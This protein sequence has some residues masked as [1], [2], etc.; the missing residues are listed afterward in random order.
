MGRQEGSR[1]TY[2]RS[3]TL[4]TVQAKQATA[5]KAEARKNVAAVAAKGVRRGATDGSK[6][7]MEAPAQSR[8]QNCSIAGMR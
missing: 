1:D 3:R 7:F 6:R 4:K 2:P 5:K 8:G